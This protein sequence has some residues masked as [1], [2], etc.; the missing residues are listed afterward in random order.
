MT[1][2]YVTLHVGHGPGQTIWKAKKFDKEAIQRA[3]DG[4]L[5]LLNEDDCIEYGKAE[6]KSFHPHMFTVWKAKTGF[7]TENTRGKKGYTPSYIP[8]KTWAWV[9]ADYLFDGFVPL[10]HK[11]GTKVFGSKLKVGDPVYLKDENCIGFVINGPTNKE[12]SGLW[13]NEVKTD[14]RGNQDPKSLVP[15][16]KEHFLI[17]GVYNPYS[18][19]AEVME[20]FTTLKS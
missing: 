8:K 7:Y 13:C 15:L 20:F 9:Y 18:E 1:F 14:A 3:I 19:D 11:A 5:H 2:Y 12:E 17:D 4:H 6:A 16:R 10:Y